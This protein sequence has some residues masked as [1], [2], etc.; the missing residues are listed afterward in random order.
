[1]V[2]KPRGAGDRPSAPNR[3][4]RSEKKPTPDGGGS[5]E[6]AST[7]GAG[8]SPRAAFWV[9]LAVVALLAVHLAL[10]ERSLI[11]E[12]PTIDEVVHMPAGLTYWQKGTFR[13]YH[14]NPPLVKMIA[15][16]PVL[17]AGPLMDPL[18]Q[19]KSWVERDPSPTTFSQTFA[20]VNAD[21]YFELF[22][23]ARMVMP[24]FTILGGLVVFAWSSRL[25]GAWAGLLSLGLWVFCPNILAHGRL[26]TTDAGSTVLGAAATYVFWRYLR[27]PTL[28]WAVAAGV[29]LGVAQ[30]SKF[31]M[32]VLYA[33]W[34]FLWLVRAGLVPAVEGWARRIGKGLG[35]GLL[36]VALS[37]LT[38]NAGYLFEGFG[39]PLG[40]FEFASG[41]LTS[42]PP[43]GIR[44]PPETKNV[45]Y[46]SIWPFAQNRFRGTFLEN[47][48][49]PL[50]SHYLLGFDEQKVEADG[51]P[52][53]F[54]RAGQALAAGDVETARREATSA[55]QSVSGY[56]VYLNGELRQSGWWYYYLATLAYK[57]PEGTW[58]IVLA[59]VVA[60]VASRR[61]REAWADEVALWTVP[62]V[63][64]LAM[65]FL[66]DIN[67]GLRY[68]LAIFPY[69]YIQAGKVVP[70]VEGFAGRGRIIGRSMIAGCLGLTVAATLTI[71]P[72]YLAY[73]NQVSGGPDRVPARLIDSNL[74]W[75]QDLVGLREWCRRNIPDQP[76]GLACFGQINPSIFTVRGDRFDWFLP[77]IKPELIR[78]TFD[79]PGA[80]VVGPA[81]ELKPGYYAVSA[82]L[83]YGLHWRLYDST[84]YWQEAWQPI[85]AVSSNAFAYFRLF[86]PIDR[87]G[88]SIY[89]YKLSEADAARAAPFWEP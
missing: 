9:G 29:A 65:S 78:S 20:F 60:L 64:L 70:W 31:S 84:P 79:A 22:H 85:W 68:V 56:P 38:I 61:S 13:L 66:T 4:D 87:I 43:G 47:L 7:G 36:I 33:V 83:L 3:S 74:D 57:V 34:P 5:S 21:R 8:A 77:P 52:N 59:S 63:V 88:H 30:L 48:P 53:R 86:E 80:R 89:I 67:L 40:S 82:T 50:P 19:M 17:M 1:L 26:V 54:R 10:A 55:D 15:S 42:P 35:H 76:I 45:L 28:K 6:I 46:A 11:A 72:H 18:Y 37:V 12:N 58:L 16:L 41:A 49:A 39:K 62:V 32:L 44:T 27:A 75:G 73:F 69:V 25:Y 51:I 2:R 14:H 24:L 23:L 71:H 81:K